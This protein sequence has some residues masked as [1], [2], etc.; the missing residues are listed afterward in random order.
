VN[1]L[2]NKRG[3][4]A[5]VMLR[6][7]AAH[8]LPAGS[9]ALVTL[10][11]AGSASA[12][13]T[14]VLTGTIVDAA[15]KKPLADVVVTVTSPALQGE[16]TVVTDGSGS[17]RIPN[18]PQGDY[19][20]R[21]DRDSFRPYARGGITLRGNSTI[22]VN[23]DLLPESVQ[24]KAEEVV[25]VGKAP[26]VDI[27]SSSTG[28]TLN[29]D[30]TNRI[31]LN[32]PGGKGAASHSFES[33]AAV[34][35][36]AAED[37]YGVG[38]NGTT[39]P[40]NAFK[41]DGV[42][43]N[44]G[45]YG[46]LATPL[47]TE[48]IKELNVVSG[49]YMPE[50]GRA[51]GGIFD[52]TTN[53]GS[54]EFHG[55]VWLN[56]SPGGLEGKRTLIQSDKSV[57]TTTT[58][59]GN[60]RDF[61][62]QVGG[63][64]LKDRLWFFGGVQAAF[65]RDI[66]DRSLNAFQID[67][68]TGQKI[69]DDATGF[70]KTTPVPGG[71]RRYYADERALQ[72][73]GKLTYLI[74]QDHHLTLSVIGTPTTSGGKGSFGY[75]NTGQPEVG[76]IVGSYDTL[77][78][79][80]VASA[81]DVSLKYQG[82]FNN[83]KQ[84][85]DLTFGWHHQRTAT[86]ASD[87][88]NIGDKTGLASVPEVIYRRTSPDLH[89]LRDFE[90]GPGNSAACAPV[91]V[92]NP[93]FDP[94]KPESAGNPQNN[95]VEP[96][97]VANYARGGA[98]FLDDASINSYQGAAVFTSLVQAAGHHV[99]KA[100]IDFNVSSYEHIK[101]YSGGDVFRE[102]GTGSNFHDYR[103]YGFLQNP[104]DPVVLTSYTAKSKTTT[105]GGFVQDSWSIMDKVTLNVGFRYDTQLIYGSDGALGLALPNQWSPRVGVIYDFTQQGRSKIFANYARYY[106]GVP[107][108]MAD[109]AFPGEPQNYS[110]HNSPPCD[111]FADPK[112]DG[113]TKDAG[114]PAGNPNFNNTPNNPNQIWGRTGGDKVPVDP[115]V[116]P[117]SSDEFVVGGEYEIFSDARLG[118]TYTHRYMNRAIE[119]MS[120]DEA[121]TYFIGN[122]GY[123]IASDFPKAIRNYDAV[124]VFFQKN[125]S[126]N[127]LANV[128]YTASSLRGNYGGLFRSETGQLDP[129]INSDFDLKSL[130]PN[131]IGQL[132][133][134]RTHSIKVYAAKD[135]I[136]PDSMDLLV[137]AS[138]RTRSGTPLN[139]LASHPIYGADEIFILPRGAGGRNDWIHNVDLKVGYSVRLSKAS[140]ASLS[141][142]IFN[143][144]N[145][146]GATARD[147]TFTTSDA[148]PIQ[149]A[150]GSAPTVADVNNPAKFTHSDGTPVLASERNPN[151][152]KP[153]AYQDPRQFR[154]GAKVT[155]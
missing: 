115:D 72:Y 21:L 26:T 77:G 153:T 85:L 68:V 154:F 79:K 71:D 92:P 113:C 141:V 145:F 75:D 128:S 83:K 14:S 99:I 7:R 3:F 50:Y 152:L 52:V 90:A 134:D 6:C 91:K 8:L 39:S 101:A 140:T 87:G 110:R 28:V 74:N 151:F 105:V 126:N 149:N 46:I 11:T 33:L 51:M 155:F 146:Q 65:T 35:P 143:I 94:S 82:S 1:L 86:L 109:R 61:G 122:P 9:I 10:I 30:F 49:G 64:I 139:Y 59:L 20:L 104:D 43:V 130:L 121:N 88:S 89:A 24:L 95:F 48:F 67:P 97:T 34:A 136:L 53:T 55:S 81:S 148:L 70:S 137:G 100:G 29:K 44:D 117:Q 13:G 108:D 66:L 63:P 41:I 84:L 123:G 111:P 147:Q 124:T 131:R 107:L 32:A 120:R 42:S 56:I 17:Y 31:S 12:Q 118:L 96:C 15:T 73:I 36:G 78:H 80:Y 102:N 5:A 22:R 127:W 132:P 18:L 16:Q 93:D 116:S 119:D 60:N 150:D 125:F 23:A 133:S 58:R 19:T 129:N 142:D 144:F 2:D 38:I 4:W 138:F 45:A 106:E 112:S 57:I 62:A 103:Q 98:G 40:E 76:N 135:F 37:T 25:V 27:S 114:R 47:S 54:N 69:L